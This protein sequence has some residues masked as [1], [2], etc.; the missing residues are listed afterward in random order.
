MSSNKFYTLYKKYGIFLIMILVFTY[1][2]I[3]AENFFSVKNIINIL[4]QTS[5]LGI[6]VIGVSIVMI[7]GGSDLSIGGQV[8]CAGM[9]CATLM[10]AGVPWPLAILITLCLAVL[11]GMFNGFLA[12]KLNVL[13]LVVTLGTML[14]LQGLALIMSGGFPIMGLPEGFSVIG[15]GY[16]GPIPVPV[17]FF[18]GCALLAWVIVNRTYFGRYLFALGGNPEAAR[19]AGINIEKIRIASYALCSF[20][21]GIAA[22]IVLSRNNAA[23]PTVASSYPFDCMTSAVL[24]GISF[25]GGGGNVS[26][27]ILGVIVIGMLNNGLVLMN[28]DSNWQNV[29]KGAILIIAVGI[30]G[31]QARAKKAK[32]KAA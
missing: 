10:K 9:I 14:I 4:R 26:N 31:L 12:V 13:P 27:A 5:M 30:D 15:Q 1:F 20:F 23:Q 7:S 25:T 18:V 16:I 29:V 2:A 6:A 11:F 28:V 24:G 17:I 32:A 21:G 3:F 19:L 8:A 22:M